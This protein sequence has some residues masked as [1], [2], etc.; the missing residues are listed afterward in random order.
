MVEKFTIGKTF[1]EKLRK[2]K[3]GESIDFKFEDMSMTIKKNKI[4]VV[5]SE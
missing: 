4:D 5:D 2:L 3:Q 1:A